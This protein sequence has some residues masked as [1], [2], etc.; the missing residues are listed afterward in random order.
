MNV[1]LT[2]WQIALIVGL[3]LWEVIWKGIALWRAAGRH[4]PYWFTT[5]LV[6]NTAG[7]LPILYLFFT[8]DKHAKEE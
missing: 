3:A 4:Q 8:R 6:I 2:S 7:V 5:M 1:S